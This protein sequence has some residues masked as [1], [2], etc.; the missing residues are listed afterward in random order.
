[1]CIC[2]YYRA[3]DKSKESVYENMSKDKERD[4][5]KKLNMQRLCFLSWDKGRDRGEIFDNVNS[6]DKVYLS[7][8]SHI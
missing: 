6:C 5:H 7:I 3:C 2:I 4:P 1:M 8:F